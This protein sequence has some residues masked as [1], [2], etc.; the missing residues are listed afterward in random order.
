MT[1]ELTKMGARIEE[2]PDGMI[3]QG[4]PLTGGS[5]KGHGDHRVVMS[6]ALASLGAAGTTEID[7]AEAVDITYPGFFE[8]LEKLKI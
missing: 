8:Q 3:I 4:S 1:A 2:K 5:V 6:L 7:T